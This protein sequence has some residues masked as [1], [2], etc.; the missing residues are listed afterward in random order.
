MSEVAIPLLNSG[1]PHERGLDVFRPGAAIL[2]GVPS[3]ACDPAQLRLL[4][5]AQP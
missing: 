3:P 1:G 4:Y 5:L 2:N